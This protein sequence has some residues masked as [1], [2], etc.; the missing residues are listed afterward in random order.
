MLTLC[1]SLGERSANAAALAVARRRLVAAGHVVVG[2]P[3]LAAVP[4][5]RQELVDEPGEV[6]GSL[7]AALDATDGLLLA[8][9]EYAGGVAG[10]MKNALDWLVGSASLYRRPLAVLSAGTSGGAHAIDELVR[11][12]SWQGAFVVATLGIASPRP[13]MNADGQ[14]TDS[15]TIAATEQWAGELARALD[16]TESQRWHMAAPVIARHGVGPERL[17]PPPE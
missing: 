4:A 10:S 13:K 9:P 15:A 17:G 7:R 2:W 3:D 11:T 12:L 8:A 16:A 14:F 6:V 1:G 5:F